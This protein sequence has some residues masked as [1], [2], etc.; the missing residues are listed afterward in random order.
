MFP[1]RITDHSPMDDYKKLQSQ[2]KYIF[3]YAPYDDTVKPD[4]KENL[5]GNRFYKFAYG[6]MI[7]LLILTGIGIVISIVYGLV[8]SR[9]S[10]SEPERKIFAIMIFVTC[11]AFFISLLIGGLGS[12]IELRTEKKDRETKVSLDSQTWILNN[13]QVVISDE[14]KYRCLQQY[15]Y[16]TRLPIAE[17]PFKKLK[18]IRKVYSIKRVDG[19]IIVNADVRELYRKHPYTNEGSVRREEEDYDRFYY[20]CRRDIRDKVMWYENMYGSELLLQALNQLM[21]N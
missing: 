1:I 4:C 12:F 3:Q 13:G 18:I 8:F 19:R 20:Y 14:Q 16:K 21:T 2:I 9:N 17:A 6:L 7:K 15:D 5:T 11:A 10:F